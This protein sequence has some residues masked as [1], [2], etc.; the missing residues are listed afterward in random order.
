MK[1]KLYF[2]KDNDKYNFSIRIVHGRIREYHGIVLQDS[3]VYKKNDLYKIYSFD[4][5]FELEKISKYDRKILNTKANYYLKET[6]LNI[7]GIHQ[8][9]IKLNFIELFKIKKQKKQTFI[10]DIEIKR[11]IFMTILISFPISII[12]TISTNFVTNH[13]NQNNNHTKDVINEEINDTII[14]TKKNERFK[15]D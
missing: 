12:T 6:Y 9:K 7:F 5:E 2:Y 3:N 15:R 1:K 10:Q 8:P 11:T 13:L 4:S 14:I